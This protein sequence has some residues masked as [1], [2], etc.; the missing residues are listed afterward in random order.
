MSS[1]LTDNSK[2][3]S[4]QQALLEKRNTRK[5]IRRIKDDTSSL[6]V[7]RESMSLH[8]RAS[9]YSFGLELFTSKVFE[10]ISESILRGSRNDTGQTLHRQKNHVEYDLDLLKVP[11]E[12]SQESDEK[13][14]S[15]SLEH[16]LKER[17]LFEFYRTSLISRL[18]EKPLRGS[19]KNIVKSL[20]RLKYTTKFTMNFTTTIEDDSQT[21]RSRSID[22]KLKYDWRRQREE[23]RL[24]V[25]GDD[26]CGQIFLKQSK[27]FQSHGFTTEELQEYKSIVRSNV[28]YIMNVMNSV[29]GEAAT[30][31]DEITEGYAQVLSQEW[32][33]SLT[34]EFVISKK[35]A[36]AVQ[37]LW[38]SEEFSMLLQS[39]HF[40]LPSSAE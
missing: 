36:E 15:Q 3:F 33:N 8:T 20:H 7:E 22:H 26:E 38:A 32:T 1:G 12:D 23:C 9:Q 30:E 11:A 18:Y 14:E 40:R 29:R 39:G 35:A 16:D 37:G 31:M 5:M 6:Y 10:R 34:S 13:S 17:D 28:K 27:I 21:E 4:E 19:T 2:A 25:L 24:L